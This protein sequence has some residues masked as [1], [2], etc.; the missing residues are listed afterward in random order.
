MDIKSETLENIIVSLNPSYLN[1]IL[2]STE[3]CNFRC[4]YCYED[5]KIGKMKPEI[6]S[7]IKNLLHHRYKTL[8][9]LEI[10][11]F[12]GEPLLAKDVIFEISETILSLQEQNP[13]LNYAAN[14][15]TN[16]Y[17]LTKQVAEELI[18]YGISLYQISLDGDQQLHNTTRVLSNGKGSF[19]VIMSNLLAL[20]EIEA[21]FTV[22]LRIHYQ[23]STYI[24]LKS[25]IDILND[26]FGGDLRFQFHF[27][28]VEQLGGENDEDIEA[29]SPIEKTE[30][31]AYLKNFVA[32]SRQ[33]DSL[34]NQDNQYICYASK[35]NSLAIRANGRI[36]KCTVALDD[37]R[38]DIGYIQEDGKLCLFQ[39]KLKPWIK[40]LENLDLKTLACPWG[41]LNHNKKIES[42]K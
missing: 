7:G 33:I 5:F 19:D 39:E 8:K 38:N 16:G 15:T 14:L 32:D 25:L 24:E 42:S 11:W 41:S 6:V 20:K 29:L 18:N 28:S 13:D 12:G 31:E 2:F 1:L 23:K 26:N 36:A 34:N 35:P 22:R 3:H 10:S 27:K 40:G 21:E 17:F 4:T 9:L 37:E 30:I